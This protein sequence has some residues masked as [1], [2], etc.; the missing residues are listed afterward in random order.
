M[1]ARSG[2]MDVTAFRNIA[3]RKDVA[4]RYAPLKGIDYGPTR[5][6]FETAV[7]QPSRSAAS[8]CSN[9]PVHA[10]NAAIGKEEA[11]LMS[12]GVGGNEID[13]TS[14]QRSCDPAHQRCRKSGQQSFGGSD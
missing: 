3:S 13:L 2:D 4:V 14:A 6:K 1:N 9:D 12:R 7:A 10:Q 5:M 8:G 11:F